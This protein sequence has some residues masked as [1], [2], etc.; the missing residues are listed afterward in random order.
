VPTVIPEVVAIRPPVVLVVLGHNDTRVAPQRV[1]ILARR[2]LR[3]LRQSLPDAR[4]VVIGPI[5]PS[6]S[7]PYRVLATRDAILRAVREVG[8]LD[9]ID[10]LAERWFT[11]DRALNTG[12]AARLISDDDH[13]NDAG[14]AH[15]A[16][17]LVRDL[18]RLAVPA[19]HGLAGPGQTA[20][21]AGPTPDPPAGAATPTPDPPAG[22][23][24]PR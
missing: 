24:T 20:P 8:G 17:L 13:P 18:R 10:P 9:W 21:A 23:A 2:S 19:G 3:R 16:R 4:I 6:G 12:N 5:W 14:H 22:P 11:G 15:I 7:L 1:Y